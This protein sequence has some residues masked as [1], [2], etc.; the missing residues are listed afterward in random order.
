VAQLEYQLAQSDVDVVK[1]RIQAGQ[2]NVR[3]EENARLA[4]SDKYAAYLDS[5]FQLEKVQMQLLRATGELDKWAL[6]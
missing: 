6:R 3:D 4:E 5:S 2:A 1:A